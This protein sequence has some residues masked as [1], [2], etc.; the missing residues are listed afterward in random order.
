MQLDRAIRRDT[1]GSEADFHGGESGV[2]PQPTRWSG[3]LIQACG[4]P[5]SQTD[6]WIRGLLLPLEIGP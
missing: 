3:G 6:D 1:K 5:S 4:K 2:I